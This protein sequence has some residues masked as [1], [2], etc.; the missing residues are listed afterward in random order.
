M[1]AVPAVPEPTIFGNLPIY[2]L[3]E[4]R[5]VN[6][7]VQ[8]THIER[9]YPTSGI[10]ESNTNPIVFNIKG[11]SDYINL[12]KATVTIKGIFKGQAPKTD[13]TLVDITD[14]SNPFF[15]VVNL[16]PHALISSINVSV[17]NRNVALN[18]NHYPYRAYLQTLLS[19]TKMYLDTLGPLCGWFKDEGSWEGF[20]PTN[21]PALNRRLAYMN[22]KKEVVYVI[23]LQTPLFQMEKAFISEADIKVELVKNHNPAFYMM[24]AATGSVEFQIKEAYLNVEKI[25]FFPEIAMKIEAEL[26]A[27]QLL[28]YV[29]DDPRMIMVSVP[30]GESYYI[31]DYLTI[32]HLPKRI[33]LAMVETD[34]FNGDA[35]K[36]CFNFQHF[37]TSQILLTKNGVEYPTPALETDFT[38]GDYFE[39]YRHL[40][41]SLQAEKSPL[42]PDITIKDFA[43]GAFITSWDMSPAQYGADDPQILVNRN[44]NIKL[45]I[46]FKK[47]L[48]S[49]ITL[50]ILYMLEMRLNINDSRQVTLDSVV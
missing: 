46:N 21:N 37:D 47:A 14:S 36:N 45:A 40:F 18:E 15:S 13:A 6:T 25:T 32:G 11:N 49:P 31:K 27:R 3:W 44:S 19:S 33:V 7:Q 41:E 24:H 38:N 17:N 43:K 8:S 34:A 26:K 1:A 16:F 48:T 5:F 35:T 23:D 22:N 2:D 28:T 10:N 30:Q 12:T 9:Y 50:I 42:L 39:S 20:N 29:M 4:P